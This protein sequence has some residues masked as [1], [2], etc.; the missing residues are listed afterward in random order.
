MN[1]LRI[2]I[3]REIF[4]HLVYHF[5]LTY[6]NWQTGTIC[7]SESFES[8]S[9][10]L[11]N[12]LWKLG[13]IPKKHRTDS[14]SA[15]V[16]KECN[17]E[18]FTQRYQALLCHYGLKGSKTNVRSP[19][20]LGDAEQCNNR[21][22]KAVYPGSDTDIRYSGGEEINVQWAMSIGKHQKA[23][24]RCRFCVTLSMARL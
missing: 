17:P 12:A 22:K 23:S 18:V 16:H 6:S 9:T 24:V 1:K 13:G 19:N 20:E 11:Q 4:E 15:A 2:T 3:Q 7:F 10:G 5:I 21:F 14:L 8:L